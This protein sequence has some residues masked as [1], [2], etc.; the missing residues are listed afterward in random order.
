MLAF[1]NAGA[2]AYP[3]P[4]PPRS[5]HP[6]T[7]HGDTRTMF[8]GLPDQVVAELG[9][10]GIPIGQFG[11]F[12][13]AVDQPLPMLAL[14]AE[15]KFVLASTTKVI[16][17]LAA[18]DLLGPAYRWR[19]EAR[20]LGELADG[21]L[22]GDLLIVGGGDARL[23]SDDLLAWFAE[24]QA[25]GLREI[26]GNIILDRLAFRLTDEDQALSP[27]P[28]PD[29]PHHNW[30]DA[31]SLNDGVLRLRVEPAAGRPAGLSLQPPLADV[32]VVNQL[33]KGR[34][35]MAKA[36]WLEPAP[37]AR[38]RQLRVTGQWGR[39]CGQHEQPFALLS[40]GDLT[41][42]AVGALWV[43]AGGVLE[44]QVVDPRIGQPGQAVPPGSRKRPDGTRA[45]SVRQSARLPQ[46]IREINKYSDNIAARA[47]LLS[48]SAGFPGEAATPAAAR[49][50][51]EQWLRTR[52]LPAGDVEVDNGSGL[53]RA[54]QA[55]PRALVQ[56]LRQAWHDQ[57]NGRAFVDSL[58]IAGVDGTLAN[59]MRDGPATGR[60]MLKTGSLLDVRSVAGY[61]RS[62]NGRVYAVAALINHP[63]APAS[64]AVL[65]SV[66]EW[67][68][69][70]RR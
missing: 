3:G 44:G 60:A 32:T 65:D 68:A 29:R 31:F 9:K 61:V 69:Q 66:V 28:G 30:P 41:A 6:P 55:R 18:L 40:E 2:A 48:L 12:V 20:L 58:P 51:L 13:Q 35:C 17:T 43:K 24:M 45:F 5:Y 23:G 54:E 56:L 15:Q 70:L 11:L 67:L 34:G 10:A 8:P 57:R 39:G 26:R 14:N 25:Q 1:A 47:L 42:R 21:R 36:E 38:L 50:R 4:A 37:D 59:R 16:T 52:G 64:T 22:D 62:A 27:R 63:D 19:T 33:R 46:L 49:A 53:S 7:A